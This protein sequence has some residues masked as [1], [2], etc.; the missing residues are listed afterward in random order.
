MSSKPDLKLDWCSHEAAKY[1]VEKW[2]YSARMPAGKLAKVGVWECG[3]FI[4]CVIFGLGATPEI[5]K[6]FGL[7]QHQ[8]CELVRVALTKHQWETS[9]IVSIALKLLAK[10]N[11]GLRVIVSFADSSQGHHG[12]IY[13]AGG[14]VFVGSQEYHAYHVLGMIVHPRT[15]H[16]RYGVGGQSIPWLRKHID[17]HAER[18]ANGIKHKYVLPLDPEMRAK[19]LPL[20]KP[21]PKRVRS[22]DSD[23]SAIHAEKGGATPTRTLLDSAVPPA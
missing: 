14:W 12:G 23:T 19:I 2:H 21:Y 15:C 6:P 11:P 22:V 13:Q 7:I 5:A 8:V 20:A 4:G 9:K 1:A 17:P 3:K 16:I 18:I 10:E